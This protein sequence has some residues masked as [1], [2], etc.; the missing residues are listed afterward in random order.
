M[1]S[2]A[3]RSARANPKN[4]VDPRRPPASD[5]PTQAIAV[6]DD[7]SMNFSVAFRDHRNTTAT[8]QVIS[9]FLCPG[10]VNAQ[11]KSHQTFGDVG[12]KRCP[13]ITELSRQ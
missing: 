9:T 4:D 10:E 8:G 13:L 11:P 6:S 2:P 5:H 12:M 3:R 7:S 1:T